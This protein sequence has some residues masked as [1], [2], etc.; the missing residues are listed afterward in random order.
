MIRRSTNASETMT[1]AN[2][3]KQLGVYI[4]H[5]EIDDNVRIDQAKMMIERLKEIGHPDFQYHFQPNSNHWW[6]ISDEPGADCVDWPPLFD[7]FARHAR[8][9]KDKIR[10]V[11]FMTAN[12]GVTSR[13]NWL[14]I[15]AQQEQLKMSEA[16]IL[17]DPYKQRFTGTTLNVERVAFDLDILPKRD[18]LSV[19]I[20]GQSITRIK[21]TADQPQIWLEKTSN[22]W[23]VVQQ[24]SA[25]YKT[26]GRYGTFKD[27]FRHNMLFV[28]GTKGTPAENQWAFDKARYDAEK[29]WYQGNG[30]IEIIP[31]IEFNAN[32]GK[33]RSVIIYGNRNT[34]SAWNF[35][36]NESPVQ[37]ENGLITVGEKKFTGNSLACMCVRPRPGSSFAYVAFVSGSGIAGMRLTTRL[38]Y[39]NPG[40]G[41]PDCTILNQDIVNTG[42]KG[43]LMTGFFG[44]DWSI[45]KGDFVWK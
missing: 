24:P 16:H 21:I 9:L 17:F 6:D 19:T 35:V 14:L 27:A 3:Y 18:T 34:N 29:F 30:G 1:F 7:F 20:D 8:P 32:Q 42:E 43:V 15:D 38:P 2:N 36:L 11:D 37:V 13:N 10:Q 28:Y 45:E 26:A 12:P 33:D 4:I 31:D 23:K 44:L 41:L 22:T 39:M 25:D 5:G 40:I